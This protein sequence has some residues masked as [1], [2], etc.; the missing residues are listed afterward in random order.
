[1]KTISLGKA[2]KDGETARAVKS[3]G[4][5]IYPTDTLYGIGCNAEVSESVIR[6]HEAKQRPEGKPFS[7]IVPS[8][9]WIRENTVISG[10]NLEFLENL[11]PG[12]YM[13]ILKAK[14]AIPNVTNREGTIGVRIPKNDFCDLIRK[15]GVVFISTS[16]NL[17]DR[18]PIF[19]IKDVPAPIREI[20]DIAV[21][22]G[23]IRGHGSRVFDLTKGFEIV[24]F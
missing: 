9:D 6:I 3:G 8:T 16:V 11:F 21:D 22:A 18:E 4:I 15:Q 12:P 20:S 2:L 19:S 1:M 10:E 24:R 7:V 23:E 14:R 17:S 5:I 13:A